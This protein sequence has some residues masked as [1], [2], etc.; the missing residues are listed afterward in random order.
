MKNTWTCPKCGSKDIV[1]IDGM[2]GAFGANGHV[3]RMGMIS[4]NAIPVT[5]YICRIVRLF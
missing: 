5:R 2:G 4:A 1:R 3:I